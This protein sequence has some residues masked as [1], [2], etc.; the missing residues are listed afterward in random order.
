MGR[1]QDVLPHMTETD[2]H[3]GRY[4]VTCRCGWVAGPYD[5]QFAARHEGDKH[6]LAKANLPQR[7]IV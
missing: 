6:M 2:Q 4:F 5:R 1:K 3:N 7:K